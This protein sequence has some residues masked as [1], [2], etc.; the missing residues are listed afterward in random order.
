MRALDLFAGAGGWDVGATAL[1]I[2]VD[3]VEVMPEATAT[4]YAAGLAT[5]HDD[6]WTMPADLADAYDGL[7][8]SPP[9]QT[10]SQAGKGTGTK[11]LAAVLSL[12]PDVPAMTLTQLHRAG[13]AFG[14]ERTGLVLTPLW[15]A[16]HHPYRWL[17]WEQVPAV[18]PVWKACTDVL[19]EHGW[20]T[21][22]GYLN[23]EQYGVPQTRKR[24][25]LLATR[26]GAITPPSPT[27]SRYY[28][29]TPDR[30]DPGVERWVS[31]AEGLGWGL[32]RRP[33]YTFTSGGARSSHSGHEW[34]SGAVRRHLRDLSES[35]DSTR[36]VTRPDWNP[37]ET[38]PDGEPRW[39]DQS[40]TPVDRD[41]PDKRPST[42]VA[43]RGLV[44]NPGETANRYNASTKSRNDGIRVSVDEAG[45]LQTFPVDFPWQGS[46]GR[47][48]LQVGNAV[49][50]LLAAHVLHAVTNPAVA[51]LEPGYDPADVP[52]FDLPDEQVS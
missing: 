42:T 4:R 50:P 40:G 44:Q 21:W 13:D 9:C 1:G 33:A 49:P 6:V 14:D 37:R 25:L 29:R 5:I 45:V 36:W 18:L 26:D 35:G 48:Y 39:R 32:V 46:R 51:Q 3:G 24:A 23:A 17:A 12:L 38:T 7:I 52:L 2:D 11:A 31:M 8:A 41:W 34:G 43:S 27:H 19:A 28:S 30:L 20:S 22:A 16:F 10:F 15:F 47:R